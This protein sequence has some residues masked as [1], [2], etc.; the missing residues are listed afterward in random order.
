MMYHFL[1]VRTLDRLVGETRQGPLEAWTFDDRADRRAAEQALAARGIAARIRSAYKP[2]LHFFLDEARPGFTAARIA[3]PHHPQ[4]EPNRFLLETYPL[5]ALF[6][7]ARLVFEKGREGL[8][9]DVTLTYP[10]GE[11]HHCVFAPNRVHRDAAGTTLLS[12]TGWRIAAGHAERL[13]TDYEQI[14]AGVVAAV[15]AQ[16]WGPAEP[17]FGEL[18]IAVGLPARDRPLRHGDEVLSLAE[19]ME[20]DLY[21]ALLEVFKR[22]TGRPMDDR[23]LQPGQI[24]PELRTGVPAEVGVTLRP[25]AT[26]DRGGPAQPLE[27]AGAPPPVAQIREVLARIGGEEFTARSRAGR[28]VAAR[29]HRGAGRPVMISAGQH[30]NETSPVVGALR[31]GLVLAAAGADFSLSPM[32]NPDGY[33]LHG[34]LARENPRHMHHAA[35]YTALGDDLE[36]REGPEGLY[37]Q[38]IRRQ[39]EAR[40]G[41]GLHVNLH[42]Y[43][44]HEW[45]RPLSGYIPR[46]F[47]MWTLP[48]GYFL[49]LRHRSGWGATARRLIEAVTAEL[50]AVPGLAEFNAQQIAL[51][52]I[53]AGEPAFEM[54][55]GFPCQVSEDNRHRVPLTL[56]TEYP[57]ETIYGAAYAAGHEAQMRTVL[58]ARAAWQDL[59][60]P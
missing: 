49:V 41:A 44:A 2:L 58:A 29:Y 6:P 15:D 32:E 47:A 25:L 60:T 52:R 11:E 17:Y 45:T 3:W 13:E 46:G 12:P 35:R 48:K 39:A 33:A 34:R 7:R 51:Y 55:N 30:A 16:A 20:E 9:Y 31:A 18:N 21:F 5:A 8:T 42:G 4:A 53:H 1:P 23:R 57:D 36:Y 40:T 38:E 19:A 10:E 37:E 54:I 50:G 59:G 14:F 27:A 56:I 28:L 43:P 26:E 22:K 24:V